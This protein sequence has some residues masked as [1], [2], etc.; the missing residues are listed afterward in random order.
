MRAE[1]ELGLLQVPWKA[2]ETGFFSPLFSPEREFSMEE[3]TY[4]Y[5]EGVHGRE[6]ICKGW[7]LVL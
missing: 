4:D 6:G 3:S 5:N 7:I 2:L 1:R